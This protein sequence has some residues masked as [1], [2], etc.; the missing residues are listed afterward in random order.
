MSPLFLLGAALAAT[1]DDARAAFDRFV[2]LNAAW[3]PAQGELYAPDAQLV[4][5]RDDG[6]RQEM[7]GAQMVAL[8]PQA[9]AAEKK[10]G[11]RY[12]F[13][14]IQVSEEAGGFRVR[15]HR[16]VHA[17]CVTDKAYTVLFAERDGALKVVEESMGI[18]SLSQCAPSDALAATLQ[19][20]VAGVTP[21][22][23]LALDEETVLVSVAPQG[24]ALVYTLNLK[25]LSPDGADKAALKQALAPGA[26]Q[27]VCGTPEMRSVLQQKGAIRYDYTFSDGSLAARFDLHE[28]VCASFGL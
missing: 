17:K 23:P 12:T 6:T 19:G 1:P 22:L 11:S 26:V 28:A 9:F 16:V 4:V 25:A 24:P 13:E 2:A 20:L 14:E 27:G 3:D 10:A 7:T 18:T 21:H 8:L 15:A 5:N